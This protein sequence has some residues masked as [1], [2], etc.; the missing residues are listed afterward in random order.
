M[1]HVAY[2]AIDG[3][4]QNVHLGFPHGEVIGD[5]TTSLATPPRHT[6]LHRDLWNGHTKLS[7]WE[8]CFTKV[9][10]LALLGAGRD[11]LWFTCKSKVA[12]F[13]E[14]RD[15][16]RSSNWDHSDYGTSK[17]GELLNKLFFPPLTS[18]FR[19][20]SYINYLEIERIKQSIPTNGLK[21]QKG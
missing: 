4:I 10:S 7:K 12:Q 2:S 21:H 11:L 16:P 13:L 3:V 20:I 9:Y 5:L 17:A 19:G 1:N 8:T 18:I 15:G 6:L 14:V